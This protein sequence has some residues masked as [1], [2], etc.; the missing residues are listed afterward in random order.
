MSHV[1]GNNRVVAVFLGGC[2]LALAARV[3]DVCAE[4]GCGRGSTRRSTHAA[5][6]GRRSGRSRVRPAA[7]G[8]AAAFVALARIAWATTS[9]DQG[10]ATELV[11]G[12]ALEYGARNVDGNKPYGSQRDQRPDR[13]PG[14]QQRRTA[15]IFSRMYT[16]ARR[17]APT[18]SS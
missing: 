9:G 3:D 6:F 13:G 10:R 8:I 11:G 1:L 18:R 2:F 17:R 16:Q 15:A 7:L 4:A 12:H 5:S 14:F